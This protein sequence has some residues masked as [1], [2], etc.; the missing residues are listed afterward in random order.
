MPPTGAGL[1]R[2]FTE[3]AH[4]IKVSPKAIMAFAVAII[5]FEVI[6]RFYGPALLGF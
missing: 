2:Y 6:L 3:E 5:I 4:G 1:I